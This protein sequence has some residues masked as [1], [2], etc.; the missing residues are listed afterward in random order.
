MRRKIALIVVIIFTLGSVAGIGGGYYNYISQSRQPDSSQGTIEKQQDIKKLYRKG[1]IIDIS[2]DKI[3]MKVEAG[4][5]DIGK[6]IKGNLTLNTIVQIGDKIIKPAGE[7]VDLQ[8]YL[9]KGQIIEILIN[10]NN[11]ILIIYKK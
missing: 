2:K 7:T 6:E 10:D 8:K 3:Y 4:E 9:Q 11:D 5:K 1:E